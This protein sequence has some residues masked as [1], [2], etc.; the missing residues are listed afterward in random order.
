MGPWTVDLRSFGL[1]PEL[2]LP[3]AWARSLR[4]ESAWSGP[5][6]G[7]GEPAALLRRPRQYHSSPW[8]KPAHRS[9]PSLIFRHFHPTLARFHVW[10]M[11]YQH[12]H[13]EKVVARG[14]GQV[15]RAL[16]ALTGG[17]KRFGAVHKVDIECGLDGIKSVAGLMKFVKDTVIDFRLAITPTPSQ[18]S[19]SPARARPAVGM[20]QA[21]CPKPPTSWPLDRLT[22]ALVLCTK[23][24]RVELSS[25][26]DM[27]LTTVVIMQRSAIL[28]SRAKTTEQAML[29]RNLNDAITFQAQLESFLYKIPIQVS[30]TAFVIVGHIAYQH[31]ALLP[32]G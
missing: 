29:K 1:R 19:S 32:K 3:Q 10:E 28:S 30:S 5:A 31:T 6:S 20:Q 11:S 25:A 12:L 17:K 7:N 14:A 2:R 27:R 22:D 8:A 15:S 16:A 23:P 4:G 21:V 18:P 24:E 26:K 13:Q 9:S